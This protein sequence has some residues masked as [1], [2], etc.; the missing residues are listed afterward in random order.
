ME[1]EEGYDRLLRAKIKYSRTKQN[2]DP[3]ER[4]K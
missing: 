4:I 1:V 3:E 2:D